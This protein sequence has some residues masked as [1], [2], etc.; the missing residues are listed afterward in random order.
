MPAKPRQTPGAQPV[1][2][3][4][5]PRSALMGTHFRA[6]TPPIAALCAMPQAVGDS[7]LGGRVIAGLRCFG[8]RLTLE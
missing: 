2:D 3:P 5:L 1:R 8:A 4:P 6:V 7:R